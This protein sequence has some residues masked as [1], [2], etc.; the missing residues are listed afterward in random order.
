M[1][2]PIKEELENRY[3][4]HPVHGTQSERYG[5]IRAKCLE[6]A[7]VICNNTP[8]SREQSF[9][10]TLLDMVMMTANAAIARNEQ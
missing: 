4:Y 5:E 6:L 9:A 10:L 1:P 2:T 3:A 7:E 8:Y